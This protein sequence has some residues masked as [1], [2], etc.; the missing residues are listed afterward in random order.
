MPSHHNFCQAQGNSDQIGSGDGRLTPLCVF[1]FFF[2]LK[3]Q[4]HSNL[5][6]LLFSAVRLQVLHASFHAEAEQEKSPIHLASV[7]RQRGPSD[8]DQDVT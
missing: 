7:W 5:N 1:V 4:P 6:I 3:K 8:S 2:F